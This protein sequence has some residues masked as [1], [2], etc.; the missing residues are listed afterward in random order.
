MYSRHPKRS[1]KKY[2]ELAE[3]ISKILPKIQ[4]LPFFKWP[5]KIIGPSDTRHRDRRC[6]YHKD[7]GHEI[8][9]YYALKDHLE[10]LVQDGRLA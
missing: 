7:H 9:S 8:D 2:T 10:E 5:S 3:P 4:Y 6:E 1:D